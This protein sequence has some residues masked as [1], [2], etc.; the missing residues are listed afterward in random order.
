MSLYGCHA[1][2]MD[3]SQL[4]SPGRQTSIQTFSAY[5]PDD[6]FTDVGGDEEGDTAPQ[7][8]AFLQQ[9]VKDNHDNSREEELKNDQQGIRC[10]KGENDRKRTQEHK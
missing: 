2:Q 1:V 5:L 9:L 7:T 10:K 3:V 8:I 4:V 6:R